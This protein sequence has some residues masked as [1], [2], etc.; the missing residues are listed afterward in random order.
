MRTPLSVRATLE[1]LNTP[2]VD[3]NTALSCNLQLFVIKSHINRKP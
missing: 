1:I 3:Y 2:N